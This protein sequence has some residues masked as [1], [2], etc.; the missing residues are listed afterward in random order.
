MGAEIVSMATQHDGCAPQ[1]L[2]AWIIRMRPQLDSC[3]PQNLSMYSM[4]A[5]HK[6]SACTLSMELSALILAKAGYP[7]ADGHWQ[8]GVG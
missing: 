3:T 5:L 7:L 2:S 8:K 1:E 6:L 4:V